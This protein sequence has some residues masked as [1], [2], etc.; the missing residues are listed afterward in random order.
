LTSKGSKR[1]AKAGPAATPCSKTRSTP[2]LLRS[3]WWCHRRRLS[4]FEGLGLD[5]GAHLLIERALASLPP[6]GRLAVAGHAPALT[7]TC[8]RGPGYVGI[9]WRCRQRMMRLSCRAF[10]GSWCVA[11]LTSSAGTAPSGLAVQAPTGSRPGQARP[12]TG[13]ARRAPWRPAGRAAF[14]LEEHLKHF[15]EMRVN[16]PQERPVTINAAAVLTPDRSD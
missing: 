1:G 5:R 7:S 14:D 10:P 2:S 16:P 4:T 3:E 15:P 8:G 9:G 13:R 6:G 12:G 11:R